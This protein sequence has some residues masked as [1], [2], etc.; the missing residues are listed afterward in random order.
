ML[1]LVKESEREG[2]AGPTGSS[3]PYEARGR[4]IIGG[5]AVAAETDSGAP[6]LGAAVMAAVP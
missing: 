2:K 1:V 5:D 6:K 4:G 3:P